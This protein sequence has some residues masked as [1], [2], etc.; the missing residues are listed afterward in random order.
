MDGIDQLKVKVDLMYIII[1]G[2]LKDVNMLKTEICQCDH[3]R[4]KTALVEEPDAPKLK[5]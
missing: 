5:S 1:K 4:L 3:H 2:L